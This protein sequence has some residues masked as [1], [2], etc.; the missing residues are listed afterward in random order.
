MTD[1]LPTA[2]LTRFLAKLPVFK[3]LKSGEREQLLTRCRLLALDHRKILQASGEPH[4]HLWVVVTGEIA[5]VASSAEGDDLTLAIFGPGS[6]SSW[7]ALFHDT[8]AER[9]LIA[10]PGSYILGIPRAVALSLLEAHPS[11]YPTVLKI[12]A[13]RFRAALNLQQHNLVRERPRRVAGLLLML[14]EMSGEPQ[15][16]PVI[17]LTSQQLARMAHCSRQS[18]YEAVKTLSALGAVQQKYGQIEIIDQQRLRAAYQGSEATL[19]G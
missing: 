18:L 14:M 11:L 10:A 4:H 17:R 12:E 19:K 16:S 13:N 2:D 7:I 9:N 3:Q 15:Q 6:T 8:P 5:M 1:D